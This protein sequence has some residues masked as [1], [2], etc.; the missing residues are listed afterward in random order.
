[1]R[2]V[3]NGVLEDYAGLCFEGMS[4]PLRELSEK[5]YMQVVY[6]NES[7]KSLVK[8][9]SE[10]PRLTEKLGA[11]LN[12]SIDDLELSQRPANALRRAGVLT[13]GQLCDLTESQLRSIRSMGDKS[14][15]EVMESLAKYGYT[16]KVEVA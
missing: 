11:K 1:M 5:E 3:D 8:G 9:N 4:V 2:F 7:N 16:L 12:Y 13:I 6:G 10:H 15:R 14:V